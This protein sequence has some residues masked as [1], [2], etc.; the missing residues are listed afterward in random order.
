MKVSLDLQVSKEEFFDFLYNS[1]IKDVKEST[2]K[3]LSK[4]DIVEGF[5]YEKILKTRV[6]ELGEI[7]I[8]L[9]EFN[10]YK[11]YKA[12]Y[13][14]KQGENI[15]EYD[16]NSLSDEKIKV[17]YREKYIAPDMIKALNFKIANFFNKKKTMQKAK[18][19]LKNIESYIINN[20]A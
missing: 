15:I 16:V 9:V 17:I 3:D 19:L 20:R 10:L 6:G 18:N 14:S 12:R 13:E 8:S 1:V 5:K 11:K 2:G 4:E 7:K